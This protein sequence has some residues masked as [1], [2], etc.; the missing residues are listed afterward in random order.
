MRSARAARAGTATGLSRRLIT[1]MVL[2]VV[3]NPINSSI[4]AVALVPIGV[5]FGAPASQTAWLVSALYLATAVGQPV[6]GRLVDVVGPKPLYLTGA[7]MVGVAGVVGA[8]A[9]TLGV[10]V[11]AR[12]LLGLGTC[13]G[14]PAAMY[15][16]RHDSGDTTPSGPLT[17]L[18]VSGQVV[19]AVGP[20]LGG[21][22][23]DTGG[24]QATFLVNVPLA[25][26]C[27]VVGTR[28]PGGARRRR[29]RLD[30][31]GMALF[32]VALTALLL[33]MMS[34]GRWYLAL[35]AAL[36]GAGFAVRELRVSDPFVDL[37][38]LGGNWPLLATFWRTLLT[39]TVSYS[40]LF[41]YTQWL[42]HGRGL[43][44]TVAGLVLLPMFLVA[45]V[46]SAITGRHP[47]VRGKLVVGGATLVAGC[48]SLLVV[49]AGTPVAAL[50]VISAVVGV[51]QG[52]NSLGNQNAL[53]HQAQPAR[54]AASA[55]L[56]RT[57][58]YLGAMLAAAAGG[59]AF[60]HGAD[61]DGLHEL[62]W[63]MLGCAVLLLVASVTDRSLRRVGTQ[64]APGDRS[65]GGGQRREQ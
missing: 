26:A 29:V 3:L 39:F 4:I 42:E 46:V 43:A 36:V 12:V 17:V 21:V 54:V 28:L 19:A 10:L 24:W 2:G 30:T 15:L 59:A 1:P 9:S 38:V 35:V 18:A 32:A 25:L 6:A 16:I 61:T 62:A 65:P 22:L 13:A 53:Y 40:F 7:V 33:F 37:R 51:P 57:F 34:P 11:A 27:L 58:S 64:S 63:L 49:H 5:A 31:P 44:P 55:G 48:A 41:G 20:T 47:T 60:G 52:L 50:A 14:Y 23:I 45:I 8:T 56:L